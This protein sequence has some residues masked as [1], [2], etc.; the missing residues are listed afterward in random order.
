MF[1]DDDILSVINPYIGLFG[2]FIVVELM[3]FL[4]LDI[5]VNARV[6]VIHEYREDDLAVDYKTKE[7]I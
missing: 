4:C 5:N 7:K 1:F 3:I 2:T 6:K